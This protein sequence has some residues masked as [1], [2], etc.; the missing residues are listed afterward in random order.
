[1]SNASLWDTQR[2]LPKNAISQKWSQQAIK[3]N[4][5]GS[6]M[7]LHLG[8]LSAKDICQGSFSE[9]IGAYLVKIRWFLLL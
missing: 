7:H 3:T 4:M 2:L 1:M 9:S 5:T 8:K 6:F